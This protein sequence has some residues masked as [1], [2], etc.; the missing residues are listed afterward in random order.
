MV[1]PVAMVAL[2]IAAFAAACKSSD[3]GAGGG[4]DASSEGLMPA[5]EAGDGGVAPADAAPERA[6]LDATCDARIV[7]C[8]TKPTQP[9]PSVNDPAA[10]GVPAYDSYATPN[11]NEQVEAACNAYC[12]ASNPSFDDA[13]GF[14]G[15][16]QT[17]A[18]QALG[19]G[20]FHC[21]CA[22]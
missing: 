17:S 13:G 21:V 2:S 9:S 18:E 16:N 14:V 7:E 11:S 19:T 6:R 20:A 1:A 8:T 4:S 10:C 3:G 5:G 22:P 12:A 15:C